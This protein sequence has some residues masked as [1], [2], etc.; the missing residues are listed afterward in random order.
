MFE[1]IRKVLISLLISTLFNTNMVFTEPNENIYDDAS[2]PP[3]IRSPLRYGKRLSSDSGLQEGQHDF[4][5]SQLIYVCIVQPLNANL[6]EDNSMFGKNKR[7][8]KICVNKK[9]CKLFNSNF[10]IVGLYRQ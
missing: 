1:I 3:T 9:L 6:F 4:N 2:V 5:G 7:F 8:C 10:K